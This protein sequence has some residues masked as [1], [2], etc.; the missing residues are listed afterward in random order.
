MVHTKLC[1]KKLNSINNV[2]K[3]KHNK[4]T[5]CEQKIAFKK[6]YRPKIAEYKKFVLKNLKNVDTRLF[7]L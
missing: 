2:D 6:Q 5:V 3:E 4:N 7:N 1:G